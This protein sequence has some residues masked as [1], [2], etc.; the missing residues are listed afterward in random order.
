MPVR[1]YF[2]FPEAFLHIATEPYS[3]RNLSGSQLGNSQKPSLGPLCIAVLICKSILALPLQGLPKFERCA[4]LTVSKPTQDFEQLVYN[5]CNGSCNNFCLAWELHSIRSQDLEK[6]ARGESFRA[7]VYPHFASQNWLQ[8]SG[9]L[10]TVRREEA[11]DKQNTGSYMVK[12]AFHYH[13]FF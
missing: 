11:L 12:I 8:F 4:G 3:L 2:I 9:V 5:F 7:S 6:G 1:G 10:C 13:F